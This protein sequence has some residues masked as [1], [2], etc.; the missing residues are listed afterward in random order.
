MKVRHRTHHG[1]VFEWESRYEGIIPNLERRYRDT[2]SDYMRNEI[3]RYMTAL[4]CE[5]CGGE[6]LRP[7]ALAVTIADRSIMQV[8]SLSVAEASEWA[9]AGQ[10]LAAMPPVEPRWPEHADA[11]TFTEA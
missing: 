9:L 10:G 8:T 3:E 7:E 1:R 11:P 2:Q 6:R 4:P 5:A